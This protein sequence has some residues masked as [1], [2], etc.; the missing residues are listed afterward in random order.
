MHPHIP[1]VFVVPRMMTHLWRKS[2]M[3]DADIS[4]TVRSGTSFWPRDMHEP[5]IVVVVL[6]L[7]HVPNYRGPWT[8]R[9]SN[10]ADELKDELEAGFKDPGLHGCEKFDDLERPM[11]CLRK[12]QEGWSGSLLFQF[13][14]KQ[15]GFPPVSG[16]V[17][18]KLLPT[19]PGRSISSSTST[20]RR[21]KRGSR[22]RRTSVDKVQ[23]GKKRRSVD[24]DSL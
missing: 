16:G 8:V 4:F 1:H 21:R 11:P 13:L 5:L 17:V 12:G 9:A 6:P 7:S 23:G 22:D 3:K 2:L 15:R 19:V 24:G 18:R 10:T 14:K 20:G